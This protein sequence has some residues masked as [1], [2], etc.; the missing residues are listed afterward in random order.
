MSLSDTKTAQLRKKITQS[1]S[2]LVA[3]EHAPR[4]FI[5]GRTKVNCSGR[6]FDEQEILSLVDASLEFWLTAGRY[7]QLFEKRFS[8]FLG[9]KHTLLVNSGSSANFLAIAALTS[10]QLLKRKLNPGDEIITAAA[11]FPTTVILS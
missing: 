3:L 9:T 7:A 11:A 4:K 6:V 8:E 10:P 2:Q 1:V 5:P